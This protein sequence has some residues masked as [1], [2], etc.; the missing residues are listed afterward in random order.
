MNK[1]ANVNVFKHVSKCFQFNMLNAVNNEDK[2]LR[3]KRVLLDKNML[4]VKPAIMEHNSKPLILFDLN[5]TLI[6]NWNDRS[7]NN[8]KLLFRPG[9]KNLRRLKGKFDL[10]IY[11]CMRDYNV[12][13]TVRRLEQILGYGIFKFILSQNHCMKASLDVCEELNKPYAMMKPIGKH[14]V[15]L[16][17]TITKIILVDDT[18]EK[19]LK[20]EKENLV[21]VPTWND[22]KYYDNTLEI[23]VTYL[24]RYIPSSGD[25]RK[26]TNIVNNRLFASQVFN[27]IRQ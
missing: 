23:L 17:K 27:I 10:G 26:K 4:S 1:L 12:N 13:Y 21:L 8:K 11:S 9:I 24:L 18:I 2:I 3:M 25:V 22:Q 20:E 16:N 19:I 6:N 14:S 15:N 7:K 5:G